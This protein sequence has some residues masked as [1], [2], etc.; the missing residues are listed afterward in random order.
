[1][2]FDVLANADRYAGLHPLFERAF[3]YLRETDFSTMALGRHMLEGDSLFA[4]VQEAEGRSRAEAQLECHRKYIDIQFVL[5][6]PDEMGW[7]PLGE[8]REPALEYSD[9]RD[10]AFFHDAP[11]AWVAVPPGA[12]CVFFPEDAHAPLV[13]TGP[14]RKIVMK[15]AVG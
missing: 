11:A 2:I 13:G 12:F 6:G 8:C 5:S 3:A 4:I 1:M 15:V 7:G 14:I 10:I 9:K